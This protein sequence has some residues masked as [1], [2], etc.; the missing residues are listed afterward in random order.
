MLEDDEK[1][2][3]GEPVHTIST[4]SGKLLAMV[5][6]DPVSRKHLVYFCKEATSDE[7]ISKLI[8]TNF[9]ENLLRKANQKNHE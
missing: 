6:R 2:T 3:D 7:I 8:K 4:K 5:R 1:I 9:A